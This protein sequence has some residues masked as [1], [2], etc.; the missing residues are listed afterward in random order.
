MGFTKLLLENALAIRPCNWEAASEPLLPKVARCIPVLPSRYIG[1]CAARVLKRSGCTW[2]QWDNYV[3]GEGG[4]GG[5]GKDPKA[6]LPA[7]GYIGWSACRVSRDFSDEF[8]CSGIRVIHKISVMK[9]ASF[10]QFP[11]SLKP[12]QFCI[13]VSMNTYMFRMTTDK[14]A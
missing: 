3:G 1:R 4:R 13:C 8:Q 9:I 5:G 10:S 11:W 6:T 14:I 12:A 7:G 2:H